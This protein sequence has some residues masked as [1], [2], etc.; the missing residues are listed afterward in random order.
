MANLAGQFTHGKVYDPKNDISRTF[1]RRPQFDERSRNYPIRAVVPKRPRGYSWRVD[2]FLDQGSEGACVGFAWAHELAARPAVNTVSDDLARV[3]IYREAQ[4]ID[5]WEGEAYDGTSVLAGAKIVKMNGYI[6]EY[7]WA[8]GLED[9]RLAVGHAG[10]AVLGINWYEGM[11]N[12][13]SLGFVRPI[14]AVVGGHAILCFSHSVKDK[15]FRLHNSWG[16][17]WGD[18]GTCKISLEDMDQL[19]HEY[20]EACIPVGR[21]RVPA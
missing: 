18:R 10:P 2:A 16:P 14:G 13:N 8:F 17:D 20:G 1:D 3:R 6:T 12:P 9:L 15:F 4:R 7:R 19:L 11:L 21:K 5:E